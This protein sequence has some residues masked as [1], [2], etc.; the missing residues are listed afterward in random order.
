MDSTKST[1][2]Y[3][4]FSMF[5]SLLTR[6][7]MHP[8]TLDQRANSIQVQAVDD[9]EWDLVFTLPW[10]GQFTVEEKQ[11]ADVQGKEEKGTLHISPLTHVRQL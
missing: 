3:N 8:K 9:Q 6:N 1:I 10:S 11:K 2:F 4:L 5:I 7:A